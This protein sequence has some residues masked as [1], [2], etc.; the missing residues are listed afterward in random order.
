MDEIDSNE[1]I[2]RLDN[3]LEV[4]YAYHILHKTDGFLDSEYLGRILNTPTKE[5]DRSEIHR[6]FLEEGEQININK[7]IFMLYVINLH[8]MDWFDREWKT[9]SRRKKLSRW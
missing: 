9:E 4:I 7:H 6:T 2:S 5:I 3:L 8:S 1:V